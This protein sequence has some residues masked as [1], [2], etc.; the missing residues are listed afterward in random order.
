M[1]PLLYLKQELEVEEYN[2]LMEYKNLPD[3]DKE[4]LKAYAREEME[5]RGISVTGV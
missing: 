4:D 3:E 2:F 1:K 5:I